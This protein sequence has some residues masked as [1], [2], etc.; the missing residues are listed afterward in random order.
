MFCSESP[1]TKDPSDM[2]SECQHY[3]REEPP[4]VG[5][6][7]PDLNTESWLLATGAVYEWTDKETEAPGHKKVLLRVIL[8]SLVLPLPSPHSMYTNM[9]EWKFPHLIDEEL[10]LIEGKIPPGTA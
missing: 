4:T 10:G 9:E 6:T 5:R 3:L 2:Q 1:D 7:I 8:Y